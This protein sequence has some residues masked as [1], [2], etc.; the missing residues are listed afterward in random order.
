MDLHNIQ[1]HTSNN[2]NVMPRQLISY[3]LLWLLLVYFYHWIYTFILLLLMNEFLAGKLLSLSIVKI[4]STHFGIH[5]KFESGI[6]AM[7]MV[8]VIK[9]EKGVKS[10]LTQWATFL[11]DQ[12]FY[13]SSKWNIIS[14]G[15]DNVSHIIISLA[16]SQSLLSLLMLF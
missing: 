2:K 5:L 12:A 3:S 7:M 9:T 11:G 4:D 1:I 16:L 8:M 10:H 6:A 15:L 14:Y 13:L